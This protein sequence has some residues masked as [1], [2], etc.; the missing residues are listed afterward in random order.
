MVLTR[1]RHGS[2]CPGLAEHGYV[3]LITSYFYSSSQNIDTLRAGLD[4]MLS[5]PSH[6]D[7]D[8]QPA[9]AFNG[10]ARYSWSV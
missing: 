10:R 5:T 8:G 1:R 6:P 2:S 4:Y 7:T 9:G 3:V